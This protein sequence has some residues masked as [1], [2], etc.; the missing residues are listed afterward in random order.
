LY[1]EVK[2]LTLLY[3]RAMVLN[4]VCLFVDVGELISLVGPNGAGKS[5]LLRAIAGLVKWEIETL[6]GTTLGKITF[7]GSVLFGGEEIVKLP[8]HE[9]AKRGLILCPERGRPFREMTVIENLAI[10]AY[11][12]QDK[13]VIKENTEKVFNLFPILKKRQNQISG[14]LS[15][16]ERTMLS[17]GRS[18]MSQTKLLLV[19]EPSTGLA[20]KIK[21][22]LFERIRVIHGMGI[23]IFLTEQ[24]VSFAFDL[25][26][27]NYVMSKGKVIREGTAQ[28]LLDDEVLRK[29]YLGL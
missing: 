26:T 9:I 10:G 18:L 2:D 14:T 15:G 19:D 23:T 25:T 24:D 7:E 21:E 11:L 4:D 28:E 17:I 20:S 13:K 1:L 5:S 3:D 22:D 29:T 8:A 6:K 12:I 27:R 16:G